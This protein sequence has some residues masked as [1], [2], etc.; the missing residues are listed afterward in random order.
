[1]KQGNKRRHLVSIQIPAAL[2]DN[3]KG[4]TYIEPMSIFFFYNRSLHWR[5]ENVKIYIRNI[6][7]KPACQVVRCF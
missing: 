2:A 6:D 4:K 3:L 5:I 7:V 1:M